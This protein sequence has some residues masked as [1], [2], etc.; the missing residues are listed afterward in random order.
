MPSR[1]IT[2]MFVVL[3][4]CAVALA[5]AAQGF[6][7]GP[8]VQNVTK[9]GATIIWETKD[10]MPGEV[11]FGVDGQFAQ[12]AS[13]AQPA[14]IHRV[15]LSGLQPDTT[16]AYRIKAGT[17]EK[18]ASFKTAPAS[19][20]PI[21]FAF[22]GDSRRW[23][24]RW[25][26][27]HM[28]ESLLGHG[29]EFLVDNGDLVL[30]GHDKSLWPEHF[31]RFA[32]LMEKLMVISG[33]GNH[34]GARTLDTGNDW[35][36]KYHEL[37]GK[38]EPFS[39]FDWGN[40]HFVLVSMDAVAGS[41]EELDADLGANKHKYTVVLFHQPVYCAGYLLPD[42]SRYENGKSLANIARVLEKHGVPLVLAGHTHI[43]E[44]VLPLRDDHRD[45]RN[46]TAYIVQGGDINANY[47]D[48]WTAFSDDKETMDMPTYT[49]VACNEDGIDL[50]TFVW[51]KQEKKI[52]EA[53]H[54]ILRADERK[55][56]ELLAS[57]PG[58]SGDALL[59]AIETLGAMLHQPAA[60]ALLSYLDKPETQL[61]AAR[62]LRS[63]SDAGVAESLLPYL[64]KAEPAAR[65]E[66]ARAI[67]IAM[68][69]S[70]AKPIAKIA[71]DASQ[72]EIVRVKLIGALQIHAPGVARETSAE[73]LKQ[74]APMEVRQ[75]AAYA[76]SRTAT[77]D[78]VRMMAKL[79]DKEPD[80]FA[81]LSLAYGLNTLTGKKVSIDSKQPIGKSE[82]GKR[83]EY[84]KKWLAE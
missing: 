43:Y 56:A 37:P 68:P 21:V 20:R 52:I 31:E 63:I 14:T 32:G 30:N 18:T 51:G 10:E 23:D 66:L 49:V 83:G 12:K 41:A 2:R 27:T 24:Q 74:N 28:T 84:V 55:A 6:H 60:K 29:I 26:E 54:V 46:G 57:L 82:P 50:S 69:D 33:R 72:D 75:R 17:E 8:H 3:S 76:L 36:A 19:E 11:A 47:P 45:D 13:E 65:R 61:A 39:V 78:D 80:R 16:Y 48:W 81:M 9:D 4:F 35:F 7:L 40:T 53:D 77:K 59:K 67:E 22:I 15:R 62:A 34:E 79:F 44:R 71:K 25:Q 70:M 42:N 1:L 64:A 73:I 38:G 5:A 58:L